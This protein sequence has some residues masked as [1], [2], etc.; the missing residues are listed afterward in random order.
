MERSASLCIIVLSAYIITLSCSG[1]MYPGI[2]QPNATSLPNLTLKLLADGF[3]APVQIVGPDD[4]TGRT[5]VADQTGLI[6]VVTKNGT[7]LNDTLLDLRERIVKLNP[8]YDERGLLGIALHPDFK[9]SS[10]VFVFYSAPLKPDA[11]K[12]WD[13]ID[14]LSEFNVSNDNP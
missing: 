10:R 9:N 12:G 5:F 13:H 1:Q 14:R 6:T 3:T 2:M 11:P 8:I 7:L 4:G